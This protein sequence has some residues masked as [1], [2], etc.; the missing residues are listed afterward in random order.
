MKELAGLRYSNDNGRYDSCYYIVGNE[1]YKYTDGAEVFLEFTKIEPGVQIYLRASSDIQ[2]TTFVPLEN[3]I[4]E[5]VVIGDVYKIDQGDNFIIT[6]VPKKDSNET[7][8][9]FKFKTNG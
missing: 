4:N 3:L 1:K 8:F 7:A 6:A 9:D 5:T 2:N